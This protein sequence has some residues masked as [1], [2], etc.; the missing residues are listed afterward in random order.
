MGFATWT[1]H[2]NL[3]ISPPE[4][5]SLISSQS[6]GEYVWANNE[7][8]FVDYCKEESFLL[9]DCFGEILKGDKAWEV[10][11]MPQSVHSQN[12]P[13]GAKVEL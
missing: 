11:A 8:T 2:K 6:I 13:V 10:M 3:I 9:A 5:T 1:G 12:A 7:K 4:T